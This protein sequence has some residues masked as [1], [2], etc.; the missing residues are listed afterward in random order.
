M[1]LI[2]QIP[3]LN[4]EET[5]PLVL[6]ELPTHLPGVDT[7]ETLII[8]DGSTDATVEVALQEGVDHIV[9]HPR[10][11]GLARAFQTG[12]DTCLQLGADI[13]VHTDA[14]N[15]YPS[16]YIAQLVEPIVARRAE[17]VIG[18]RPI[19]SIPHFSPFKK[20]LQ[21]VGSWVVRTAS[22]TDVPDTTSGFRAYSRDFVLRYQ[23]L[24]RFSYTLETI[25]MAGQMG[26]TILHVPIDVNDPTRESRLHKGS[27]HFVRRQAA[28]IVRLY[29]FYEP[30][31]TFFYIALPFLLIGLGLLMRFAIRYLGGGV[32]LVQSVSIGIGM[33]VISVFIIAFGVLADIINKHRMLT[34]ETL[35][36]LKKIELEPRSK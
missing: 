32:G 17:M 10:N 31:K 5:L 16:H 20:L 24:T 12:L 13:I 23:S 33:L 36:R 25:I 11:L 29:A 30:L 28:T 19:A 34:E 6:R 26:M 35:Y 21:G 7:I 15:Q 22:G 27:F 8:D 1:K 2:I 14:D 4:E 9:S 3:C 18:A